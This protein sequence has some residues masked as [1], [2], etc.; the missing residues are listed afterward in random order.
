MS[1]T[2]AEA[3]E[4]RANI[5]TAAELLDDKKASLSAWMFPKLRVS[6]SLLS[7]ISI[8]MVP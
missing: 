2:R 6:Q 1:I 4:M 8:K 5:E 7:A 3:L